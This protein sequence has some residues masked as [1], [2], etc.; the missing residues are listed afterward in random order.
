ML[1]NLEITYPDD[2]VA[3]ALYG[4]MLMINA[5]TLPK[6]I[7]GFGQQGYAERI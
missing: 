5:F 7:K 6:R 4:V 3:I 1:G 2:E